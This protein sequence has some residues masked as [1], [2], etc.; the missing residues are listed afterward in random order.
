MQYNRDRT[1]LHDHEA[2][3]WPDRDANPFAASRHELDVSSSDDD[4]AFSTEGSWQ[5]S[6]RAEVRR[7]IADIREVVDHVRKCYDQLHESYIGISSRVSTLESD[8]RDE[9]KRA[10]ATPH[11]GASA[12]SDPYAHIP[13]D[14]WRARGSA[15]EQ[16][17]FVSINPYH[18]SS[19]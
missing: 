18:E 7:R 11:V 12:G 19:I 2:S 4:E 5:D 14:H 17:N 8:A 15:G 16:P 9:R 6:M 10:R 13:D 1:R 3:R